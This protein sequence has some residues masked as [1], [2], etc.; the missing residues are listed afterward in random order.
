MLAEVSL[1]LIVNILNSPYLCLNVI[2][3]PETFKVVI[4]DGFI[5]L[6]TVSGCCFLYRN[7]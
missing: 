4:K 1:D 5:C 6:S 3:N 7:H 2:M